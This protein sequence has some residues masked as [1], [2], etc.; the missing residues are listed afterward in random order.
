MIG[1]EPQPQE[2]RD[3]QSDEADQP[4]HGDRGADHQRGREQEQPLHAPDLDA[5]LLRGLLAERQQV[6]VAQERQRAGQP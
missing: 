5:E 6:Q 4:R 3:D 1:A 2:M